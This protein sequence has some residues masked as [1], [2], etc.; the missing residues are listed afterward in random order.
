VIAAG[1]RLGGF[2]GGLD[3]KRKLLALEQSRLR[4][5]RLL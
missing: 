2:G 1:G 4:D 3:T 5:G